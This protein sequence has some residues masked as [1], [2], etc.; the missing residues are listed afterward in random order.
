MTQY[1]EGRIGR[2]LATLEIQ[3]KITHVGRLLLMGFVE[4]IAREYFLLGGG[5]DEE[6]EKHWNSKRH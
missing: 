2:Y 3:A 4:Q 6:F 1:N 5:S